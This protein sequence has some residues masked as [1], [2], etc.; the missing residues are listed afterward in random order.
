MS[1]VATLSAMRSMGLDASMVTNHGWRATARTLLDEVLHFPPHLIEHQLAHSVRDPLG[2]SYNRTSHLPQ[3]KEM[4]QAWS[5]FLD[6]KLADN[7]T[8]LPQKRA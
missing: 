6:A 1:Q 5:D 4:M 2:R 8:P 3:R 7:V